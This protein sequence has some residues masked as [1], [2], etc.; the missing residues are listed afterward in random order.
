VT[1]D[2][3]L[4]EIE[5]MIRKLAEKTWEASRKEPRVACTVVLKLKTTAFKILV[6]RY[7][8]HTS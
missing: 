7:R 3:L 5:T 6:S 2:V 1:Q 8:L 4:S